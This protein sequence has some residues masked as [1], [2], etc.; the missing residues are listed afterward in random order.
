MFLL[1]HQG[2]T[3]KRL[4]LFIFLCFAFSSYGGECEKEFSSKNHEPS[5]KQ[6]LK[7][8]SLALI[9]EIKAMSKPSH[10]LDEFRAK[11]GD[12]I[13]QYK[14]GFKYYLGEEFQKDPEKAIYWTEKS[15]SQGY[16]PAQHLLVFLFRD[17]QEFEKALFWIEKYARSQ[18]YKEA[19]HDLLEDL[20]YRVSILDNM[21]RIVGVEK[22]DKKAFP[23]LKQLAHQGNLPAQYLLAVMYHVGVGVKEDLVQAYRWSF[24]AKNNNNQEIPESKLPLLYSTEKSELIKEI[25]MMVNDIAEEL[26]PDQMA[27]AQKLVNEFKPQQ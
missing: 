25:E 24:L 11:R 13:S 9:N 16:P 5:L 23:L 1:R 19:K 3:L 18:G 17:K 10:F 26:T 21:Y 27:T 4:S 14:L 8:L 6:T 22:D 20:E 12:M 2:H 7:D 15:A